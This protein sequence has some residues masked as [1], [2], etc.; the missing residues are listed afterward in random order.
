MGF[1]KCQRR[2]QFD[3]SFIES[4]KTAHGSNDR[5]FAIKRQLNEL[6]GSR[7]IEEKSYGRKAEPP[8]AGG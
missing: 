5:R 3:E 7:I 2:N 6:L 4:A 1:G 8:A